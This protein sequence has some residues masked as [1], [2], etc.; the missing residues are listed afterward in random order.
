MSVRLK[1][2][3]FAAPSLTVNDLLHSG[4]AHDLERVDGATNALGSIVYM[5][6]PKELP[7][8][9]IP[10]PYSYTFVTRRPPV[11]VISRLG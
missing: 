5:V 3:K 10:P 11:P 2:V 4:Q 1:Y 8:I 6:P 7:C 9:I